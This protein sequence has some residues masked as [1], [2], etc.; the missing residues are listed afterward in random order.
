MDWQQWITRDPTVMQG[1][2]VLRGTRITVEHVLE[3]MGEGW[4]ER[5]LIASYPHLKPEHIRAALA[6]AAQALASDEL[7]FMEG[8]AA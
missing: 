7:L 5:D 8:D 1:K 3:R 6:F 2:P 4:S